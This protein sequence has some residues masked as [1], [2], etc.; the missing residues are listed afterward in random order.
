MT[1]QPKTPTFAE[2]L[3]LAKRKGY[4]L[5]VSAG[6]CVIACL[7]DMGND[8]VPY[9]RTHSFGHRK[10]RRLA[11]MAVFGALSALPDAPKEGQR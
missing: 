2:L 10:D 8:Q 1:T 4:E 7:P 9:I 6:R 3:R 5:H 11:R